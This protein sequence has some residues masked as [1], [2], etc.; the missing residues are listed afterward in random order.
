MQFTRTPDGPS[1]SAIARL[2]ASMAPLVA[3]YIECSRMGSQASVEL[4]LM[5]DPLHALSEGRQAFVMWIVP[6]TLTFT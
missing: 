3:V 6:R 4:T 2:K 5:I 1:S